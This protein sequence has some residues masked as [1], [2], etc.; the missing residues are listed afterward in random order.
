[1][2]TSHR[3]SWALRLL[4]LSEGSAIV[5][6]TEKYFP[7]TASS[8]A[9]A[10]YTVFFALSSGARMTLLTILPANLRRGRLSGNKF[11]ATTPGCGRS[12]KL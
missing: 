11:V 12:A 6:F 5:L 2:L 4:G 9:N 7:E 1:M 3:C 8:G 10:R